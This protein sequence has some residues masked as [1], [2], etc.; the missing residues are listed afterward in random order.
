MGLS[1]VGISNSFVL[2][3]RLHGMEMLHS[4]LT[5]NQNAFKLWL[6]NW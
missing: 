2:F 5:L 6:V 4:D 3:F 1:P